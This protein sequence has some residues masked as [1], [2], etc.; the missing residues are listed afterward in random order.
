MAEQRRDRVRADPVGV[1]T[2]RHQPGDHG[3]A[4]VRGRFHQQPGA[5]QASFVEPRRDRGEHRVRRDQL[6]EPELAA[7]VDDRVGNHQYPYRTGLPHDGG[8]AA[9]PAQGGCGLAGDGL[10]VPGRDRAFLYPEDVGRPD[11]RVLHG[12]AVDPAAGRLTVVHARH[13]RHRAT[14]YV[15]GAAGDVPGRPAAR[16]VAGNPQLG[17]LL[18][19][20]TV[21]AHGAVRFAYLGREGELPETASIRTWRSCGAEAPKCST[22]VQTCQPSAEETWTTGG[23][24]SSSSGARLTENRC[25]A[26][27]SE[28]PSGTSR[29]VSACST[30]AVPPTV[31][32]SASR[33]V[34]DSE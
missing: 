23:S 20:R 13:V 3:D 26:T 15:D 10:V 16:A 17:A 4:L 7:L 21:G 19:H 2:V 8:H 29:T 12:L 5:D 14:Q 6:L 24:P 1:T 31:K 34:G 18:G 32:T 28:T 25:P 33:I 22:A 27:P 30:S 11:L 9:D